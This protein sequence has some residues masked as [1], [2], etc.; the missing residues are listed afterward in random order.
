MEGRKKRRKYGWWLTA[1]WE[2]GKEKIRREQRECQKAE[3][4]KYRE[5][6]G[7]KTNVSPWGLTLS[8]LYGEE[9]KKEDF[10][11]LSSQLPFDISLSLSVSY[12]NIFS[13]YSSCWNRLAE[14]A[15]AWTHMANLAG[16]KSLS[17][18]LF[19]PLF[20]PLIRNF[21]WSLHFSVNVIHY[22]FP[23]RFTCLSWAWRQHKFSLPASFSSICS[24]LA[25]V[26]QLH[27]AYNTQQ[28]SS[29]L[30]SFLTSFANKMNEL[31]A[32]H[33][34]AHS[35][36]LRRVVIHS[37]HSVHMKKNAELKANLIINLR[38]FKK[39]ARGEV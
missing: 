9:W 20:P 25:A 11:L 2:G 22:L 28:R 8:F 14:L 7:E 31:P 32:D 18:A 38:S 6:E 36:V 37:F 29:L 39:S 24:S 15:K 12:S 33:L 30:W 13:L 34:M 19:R 10:H 21:S 4:L 3:I 17:V 35:L 16:H 23:H 26:Q 27:W 1:E 5:I